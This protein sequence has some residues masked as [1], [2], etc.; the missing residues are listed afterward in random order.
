MNGKNL[1][2]SWICADDSSKHMTFKLFS[3]CW[4][5]AGGPGARCEL[6][7]NSLEPWG[8]DKG[9]GGSKVKCCAFILVYVSFQLSTQIWKG[10]T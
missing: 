7:C 2:N 9:P 5:P 10:K 6:Q 1:G 3:K 4:G 8:P